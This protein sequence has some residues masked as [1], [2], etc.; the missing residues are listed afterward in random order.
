L[1]RILNP[2]WSE[3][4]ILPLVI[5]AIVAV[6]VGFALEPALA[7]VL[8]P[9]IGIETPLVRIFLFGIIILAACLF[10]EY[11]FRKQLYRDRLAEVYKKFRK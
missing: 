7:K 4:F 10:V 6:L 5:G 11:P 3:N 1:K 8:P 9:A 2:R